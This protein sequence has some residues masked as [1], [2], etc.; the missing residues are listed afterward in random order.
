[1]NKNL[2]ISLII[3]GIIIFAV[4]GGLGVLYQTRKNAPQVENSQPINPAIKNLSSKVI[5]SINS[6]GQVSKIEGRDITLI[7]S[8]ESLTIKAKEDALIFSF[9]QVPPAKK[10]GA[11]TITQQKTELKDIKNGDNLMMN[12]KLLSDGQ[13]EAQSITILPT[14]VQNQANIK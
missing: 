9:I 7:S 8:G 3:V 5:A 13:L 2:T 12:L 1:M 6:S 11:P 10:G 4:G 14:P